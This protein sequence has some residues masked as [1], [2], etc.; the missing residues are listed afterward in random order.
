[1]IR[2]TLKCDNAHEFDGWFASAA[3]FDTQAASGQVTCSLCGSA[4]VQKTLMAPA[5]RATRRDSDAP[6]A[7]RPDPTDASATTDAG[8]TAPPA[9]A[10]PLSAPQNAMETAFAQLR[11]HIES[12]SENVGSDFAKQARAMHE[13][14]A[15]ERAIH[16]EAKLDDAR[17]L[18]EDGVPIMPLPFATRKLN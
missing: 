10:K 15:P 2:Y 11:K 16:G 7:P 4:N 18:L 9:A 5:V 1:M 12:S 13:G 8:P 6:T 17:A 14:S 3:A